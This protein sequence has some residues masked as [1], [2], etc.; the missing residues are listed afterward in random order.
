VREIEI[1]ERADLLDVYGFVSFLRLVNGED[2]GLFD[3]SEDPG[4]AVFVVL[5]DD[6]G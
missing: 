5:I 4:G 3:V 6:V 2:G 1:L